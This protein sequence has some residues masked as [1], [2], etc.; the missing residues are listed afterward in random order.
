MSTTTATPEVTLPVVEPKV[1]KSEVQANAALDIL[2]QGP[3]TWEQLKAINPKYP[4]DPIYFARTLGAKIRTER[5]VNAENKKVTQY[6]LEAE[7]P[8]VV[9]I[10]E[11]EKALPT[12]E[13]SGLPEFTEELAEELAETGEGEEPKDAEPVTQ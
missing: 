3:A 12:T 13:E 6:I 10:D 9:V 5:V 11:V 1:K 8:E 4:S 7:A 2:R